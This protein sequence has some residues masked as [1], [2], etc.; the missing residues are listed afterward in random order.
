ME[1]EERVSSEAF[2]HVKRSNAE[3]ANLSCVKE[4]IRLV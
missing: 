4:G 3:N 1:N 2:G